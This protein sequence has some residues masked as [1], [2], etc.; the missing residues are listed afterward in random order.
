MPV[1]QL[2]LQR[3]SAF[4]DVDLAL[5]PGINVLLGANSTGKTH[6][7]KWLYATLKTFEQP[8]EAGEAAL[9]RLKQKLAGVFLPDKR[10]V[11]RLVQRG[12]GA[13]GGSVR[14][15]VDGRDLAFDLSPRGGVMGLTANWVGTAPC[16]F[17]PSREALAMY[18][19]FVAAYTKREL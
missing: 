11:G 18:E 12:L 3:L 4:A 10:Q 2:H 5:A 13:R 15:A 7:L 9:P 16:V 17:L 1:T 6:V 19:G 8:I 14:L